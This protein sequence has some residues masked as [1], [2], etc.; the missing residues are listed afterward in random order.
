M[1]GLDDFAASPL[2][3]VSG[4]AIGVVST[5]DSPTEARIRSRNRALMRSGLKR[6]ARRIVRFDDEGVVRVRAS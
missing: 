3:P 1:V 6:T 4:G 5:T 2:N